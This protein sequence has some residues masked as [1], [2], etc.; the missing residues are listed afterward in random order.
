MNEILKINEAFERI[1]FFAVCFTLLVHVGACLF[2]FISTFEE[3][4]P[5]TWV[6]ANGF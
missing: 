6:G 5:H 4:G 3:D 1:I 2:V